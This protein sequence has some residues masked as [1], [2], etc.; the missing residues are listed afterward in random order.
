MRDAKTREAQ[1]NNKLN[2]NL[3]DTLIVVI[4]E[5]YFLSVEVVGTVAVLTVASETTLDTAAAAL[6]R[7]GTVERSMTTLAAVEATT[8]ATAT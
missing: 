4:V 1:R 2:S 5:F 8:T 7:F 3:F 6:F